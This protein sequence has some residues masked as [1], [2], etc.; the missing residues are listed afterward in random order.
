M[1]NITTNHAITYTNPASGL[2]SM[3]R[4]DW[5]SYYQATYYS[6]LVAKA[7]GHVCN[8]LAAKKDGSL[9]LAC[10]RCLVSIFFLTN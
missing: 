8:V 1:P 5:L 3:L 10:E 7:A 9:A 4:S 2:L 6:P